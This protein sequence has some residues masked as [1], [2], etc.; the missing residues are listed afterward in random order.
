MFSKTMITDSMQSYSDNIEKLRWQIKT[1]DAVL[2]GAGAGLSTAAG[3]D[4]GGERFMKYFSDFHEKY[5]I[6]NIYAGGFYPFLTK[7][8]YFAW[9]SRHVYVNRYMNEEN[10]LYRDLYELVKDKEHFVITTNVDGLFQNNG[11]ARE[12][13]FATQGDY[14]LWQCPT[15]CHKETYDN[16][17]DVLL[18]YESQRDMKVPSEQIPYCPKCGEVFDMN[19]RKDASFV[20]DSHWHEA[21]DAYRAFLTEN[22]N[23]NMLLLELGVGYNTPTIIKF[24]FWQFAA[25]YKKLQY[26]AVNLMEASCPKELKKR[27]I[28]IKGDIEKVV[29]DIKTQ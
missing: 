24:A 20:E 10:K 6:D 19:L 7:E 28:L 3:H 16:R 25:K 4:Y 12:S 15:P 21:C 1:S 13:I 2:I 23:K 22:L 8:E 11:F 29:F 18:M 26:A 14:G 17:E 5:D 9:W 27:S